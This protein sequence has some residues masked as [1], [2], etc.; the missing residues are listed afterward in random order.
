MEQKLKESETKLEAKIHDQEEK[1]KNNL[2]D[3]LHKQEENDQK[4]L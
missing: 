3:S 4:L 1:A 2:K